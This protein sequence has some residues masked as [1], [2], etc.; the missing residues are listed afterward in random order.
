[1]ASVSPLRPDTEEPPVELHGRA[2]D[3]LR[4]IRDVMER[5]SAFTAISGWGQVVIGVAALGAGALARSRDTVEGWLAVWMAAALLAVGIGI[6]TTVVKARR[7]RV[8]LT[9]GPA[10]KFVLALAPPLVAGAVLTLVLYRAG[11]PQ[12]LPGTWLLLFGVGILAAG[13]FSVRVVPV[14]GLCFMLLGTAAVFLPATWGNLLM[15]AGFG[16]LH[17]VFGTIIARRHGG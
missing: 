3:N 10:R 17:V 13:T 7:S 4:Y 14:M 16:G 12:A 5:A 8:S 2:F 9:H 6:G 15:A 11:I 1:M